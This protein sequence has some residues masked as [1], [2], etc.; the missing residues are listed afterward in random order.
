MESGYG[1]SPVKLKSFS[2]LD[3]A[4]R[5]LLFAFSLTALVVLLTSKQ[6][7]TIP[8]LTIT[9]TRSAKFTNSPAFM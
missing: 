4:L 3:F 1:A 9:I 8:V 6:T 7:V 5:L 2:G